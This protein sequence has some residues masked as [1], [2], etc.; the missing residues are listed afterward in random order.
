MTTPLPPWNRR[1]LLRT[2][3]GLP[4]AAGMASRARAASTGS[5]VEGTGPIGVMLAGAADPFPDGPTLLVAGPANSPADQWASLMLPDLS[6]VL[7]AGPRLHK[8]FSGGSDGV[9]GANQFDARTEPDGS[10]ALVVP[11]TAAMAWLVG[12]TRTHFDIGQWV[13]L[14]AVMTHGV[15]CCRLPRAALAPGRPVRIAAS[16]AAG[17]ELPAILAMYL[18][19]L[20]VMPVYGITTADE[21][22]DALRQGRVDAVFLQG[23]TAPDQSAVAT[24]AGAS[25]LFSLGMLNDAGG[26][27]RDPVFP[28]TPTMTEMYA[29]VRGG[30]PSGT[31]FNAWRATAVAAQLDS[32]AVLP[33]LTPAALV[34]QW[35]RGCDQCVA[36]VTMQ[37]AAAGLSARPMATPGAA[38]VFATLAPD[39]SALLELRRWLAVRLNWR[40]I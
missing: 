33:Q 19:G 38:T 18:M 20:E 14:L 26:V 2:L 37:A 7:P 21:A 31:L 27:A 28:A 22:H 30:Q 6:R 29:Q 40:P 4:L 1:R 36:S 39:A 10:T 11:G 5:F 24:V 16:S 17:P 35:R 32:A 13:P 23:R 3:A 8:S 12:D 9:T 15:V 25:P 34:A